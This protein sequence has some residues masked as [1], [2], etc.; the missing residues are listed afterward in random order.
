MGIE[1]ELWSKY[2]FYKLNI[3]LSRQKRAREFAHFH[4]PEG[5]Q[6]ANR[7]Q[8]TITSRIAS[9]T[10]WGENT[11][12]PKTSTRKVAHQ[13]LLTWKHSF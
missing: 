13:H 8:K 12:I 1:D 10:V 3:S 7:K 6:K 11:S 2:S 9:C 5:K 4:Y